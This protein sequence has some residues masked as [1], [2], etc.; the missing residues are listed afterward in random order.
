[1]LTYAPAYAL[2]TGLCPGRSFQNQEKA[3]VRGK[4]KLRQAKR[5]QFQYLL[6]AFHSDKIQFWPSLKRHWSWV[7]A[8]AASNPILKFSSRCVMHACYCVSSITWHSKPKKLNFEVLFQELAFISYLGQPVPRRVPQFDTEVYE[9]FKVE[10][11]A[12]EIMQYMHCACWGLGW[13]NFVLC[14]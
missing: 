7:L 9:P 2:K 3:I 1:M 6:W 11:A 13:T 8:A 10:V 4:L 5:L 12:Y 14:Q